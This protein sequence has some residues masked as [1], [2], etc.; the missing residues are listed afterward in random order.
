MID[1]LG[2]DFLIFLFFIR[3]FLLLISRISLLLNLVFR[4]QIKMNE[5]LAIIFVD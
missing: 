3:R 5:I 1:I 4:K 2:T